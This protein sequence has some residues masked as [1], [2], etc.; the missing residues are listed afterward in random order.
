MFSSSPRRPGGGAA[1]PVQVAAELREVD[2]R[3]SGRGPVKAQV[4]GCR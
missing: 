2:R 4:S 1:A 3:R